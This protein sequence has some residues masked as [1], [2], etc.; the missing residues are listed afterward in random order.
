MKRS[1][2]MINTPCKKS[3]LDTLTDVV[4]DQIP[5]KIEPEEKSS[6][7]PLQHRR[8]LELKN[9]AKY[10][11]PTIPALCNSFQL[12]NELKR[13]AANTTTSIAEFST[14]HLCNAVKQRAKMV[15][16]N[17]FTMKSD[18]NAKTFI[19][20]GNVSAARNTLNQQHQKLVMN[21]EGLTDVQGLDDNLLKQM[22]CIKN[23]TLLLKSIANHANVELLTRNNMYKLLFKEL[24]S[25]RTI[26]L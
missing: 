11:T 1:S 23:E 20:L 2:I 22:E 25:I 4:C 3:K 26:H 13:D 5:T 15:S 14:Q 17:V 18:S 10:Q 7:T 6:V 24:K 12:T 19:Q 8:V 9:E 21:M 16:T